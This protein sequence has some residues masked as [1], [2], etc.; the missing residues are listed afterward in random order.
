M[1]FG[2]YRALLAKYS[3][4]AHI[5]ADIHWSLARY[6][7]SLNDHFNA[8]EHFRIITDRYPTARNYQEEQIG[9]KAF[10]EMSSIYKVNLRNPD[11]HQDILVR[12]GRVLI[13]HHEILDPDTVAIYSA[14]ILEE[15]PV[16]SP[17]S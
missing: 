5:Q 8:L 4:H 2:S 17:E 15:L 7:L 6:Y 10:Q 9:L 14:S 12:L 3:D 13:T 1:I 16:D 11:Y